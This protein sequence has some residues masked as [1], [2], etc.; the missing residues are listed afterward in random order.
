MFS[1]RVSIYNANH[2]YVVDSQGFVFAVCVEPTPEEKSRYPHLSNAKDAA[3]R[4]AKALNN[5]Q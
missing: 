3:E 4:I 2:W 5:E 1:F